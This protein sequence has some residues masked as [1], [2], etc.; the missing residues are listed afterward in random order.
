MRFEEMAA[1]HFWSVPPEQFWAASRTDR[2]YMIAFRRAQ[3]TIN[4]YERLLAKE[5]QNA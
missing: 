4:A 5:E 1:A 3:N 2:A